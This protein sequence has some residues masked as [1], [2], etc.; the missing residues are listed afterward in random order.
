MAAT[1][2]FGWHDKPDAFCRRTGPRLQE[3]GGLLPGDRPRRRDGPPAE[4]WMAYGLGDVVTM[5]QMI[6]QSEGRRGTQARG[7]LSSTPA[8]LRR[9]HR[10]SSPDPAA[11]LRR[12][13]HALRNCDNCQ[14]PL[15]APGCHA[16]AQKACPARL[17][18]T[19]AL[20]RGTP[21]MSCGEDERVRA[22]LR[23]TRS[24]PG[25]GA[26]PDE[27]AMARGVFRQSVA[28]WARRPP[29]RRVAR[30]LHLTEA[31]RARGARACAPAP[32][33]HSPTASERR[34]AREAGRVPT[35]PTAAWTHRPARAVGRDALRVPALAPGAGARTPLSA[36]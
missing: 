9:N 30:R 31:S 8:G 16:V 25:I 6:A 32:A 3:R 11:L 18:R 1:I 5:A 35:Q 29:M 22:R 36:T 13:I 10:L 23:T 20:R 17:P 14:D 12:R 21:S 2:A 24:P 33:P 15:R 19:G 4:A 34:A 28:C 26:E 7:A 27:T